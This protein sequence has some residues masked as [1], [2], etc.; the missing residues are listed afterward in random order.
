ML[1]G[2][3]GGGGV[4]FKALVNVVSTYSIFFGGG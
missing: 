3:G 1:E 4:H 2:G